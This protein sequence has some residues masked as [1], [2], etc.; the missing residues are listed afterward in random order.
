[1]TQ[2]VTQIDASPAVDAHIHLFDPGFTEVLP[3][4]CRRIAPD[5]LT[6]YRVLA[7]HHQIEQ[8]LVVGYEGE[9]WA[10]GNNHYIARLAQAHSWIR[11]LAY[12][13]HPE[14]L[15]TGELESLAAQGFVGISLYLFD[16][17]DATQAT[18]SAPNRLESVAQPVWEW[19]V[20]QRWLISV[21]STG[22]RWRDWLPVLTQHPQLRLLV[23]HLGL[24]PR[25]E[26][27]P[28]LHGAAERLADVID[29]AVAP[30]VY[31]KVSGLYALTTPGYDYPHKAAWPYIQVLLERFG[32][33]RLLWGSDFSPALEWVSF[34]QT[35]HVPDELP[36]LNAESRR[37]ICYENL[38]QLLKE[39]KT[40]V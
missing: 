32:V 25:C 22:Q 35:R 7:A 3:E 28:S 1:M 15:T 21:N 34:P 2:A 14:S 17:T 29:L 11:P 13:H 37:A 6:L 24:P 16:P 26:A 27:A 38:K 10:T 9:P 12:V 23:S 31:I 8:A 36:F 33:H 39:V 5:E 30:N 18:G 4:S 20:Q 19:L 40:R